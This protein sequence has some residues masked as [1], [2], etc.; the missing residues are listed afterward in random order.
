MK[1]ETVDNVLKCWNANFTFVPLFS[2]KKATLKRATVRERERTRWKKNRRLVIFANKAERKTVNWNTFHLVGC[3]EFSDV[4]STHDNTTKMET[5]NYFSA[6]SL[7]IY[8]LPRKIGVIKI[9]DNTDDSLS[10]SLL[11][12]RRCVLA[13]LRDHFFNATRLCFDSLHRFNALSLFT[14]LYNNNWDWDISF[15]FILSLC[16]CCYCF[17]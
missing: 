4:L 9:V 8:F 13:A 12:S 11:L 15:F 5:I 7:Y 2:V 16:V 14:C 3:Y 10:L 1:I 17:V 6:H